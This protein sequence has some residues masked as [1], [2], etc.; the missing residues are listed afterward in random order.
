MENAHEDFSTRRLRPMITPIE[1]EIPLGFGWCHFTWEWPHTIFW[2]V[3]QADCNEICWWQNHHVRMAAIRSPLHQ[4][5][6]GV[7]GPATHRN[8]PAGVARGKAVGIGL[9]HSWLRAK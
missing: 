4:T 7:A 6:A 5:M 2:G 9:R 1:M 8:A 3:V